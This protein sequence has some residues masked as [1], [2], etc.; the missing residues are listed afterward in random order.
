MQDQLAEIVYY[1][2]AT[3]RY[4]WIILITAWLVCLPA[5]WYVMSL[6]DQY[7]SIARVQ[8]DTRTMLRPL[9][10]GLAIQSDV[11]GMVDVMKQLMFIKQNLEKIAELAGLGKDLKT[12]SEKLGLINRLK[13]SIVIEGGR[14]EIFSISYDAPDPD[15]AKHVVQSVLTVF[16]E[17]AQRSTLDDADSAQRFL[18]TQIQ[19]YE[20]RLRNAEKARENFKRANIGMLPGQGADQVSQIQ[21]LNQ[22]LDESRLNLDELYSR[23][24]VLL[25]QLEEAQESVEDE[26]G[27]FSE[28]KDNEDPRIAELISKRDELLLRYTE[29]HP[30]VKVINDTIKAYRARKLLEEVEMDDSPSEA[31][32]NPFVQ[33]IKA[34][35]NEVDAQ[36]ASLKSRISAYEQRI[37]KSDEEFN[38][39]LNIETQMQNLNRDYGTIK[40]NYQSLLER[41]EQAA[42]SEKVDNQSVA[43]KFKV[44]D[45]PNKPL[46]PSGPNRSLLYTGAMAG[47]L[48][49]GVAIAFLMVLLK[50]SFMAANQVRSITG[51]PILG[52]VSMVRNEQQI[53]KLRTKS[54][55]FTLIFGLL[56]SAYSGMMFL[57]T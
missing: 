5:W 7:S 51:L 34:S 30:S 14:D 54:I 11:R 49:A 52:T 45:P 25:E 36:I 43:L 37:K 23:K 42:M 24:K 12:E 38:E 35:S 50:P 29:K 33:S 19:E 15:E 55:Q 48:I 9:L 32:S 26:W 41:K 10:R 31:L 22:T 53:K 18:M 44:A 2:K 40:A 20:Q 21:H 57:K 47:G 17:Q 39:R 4:K 16:S 1:L 28:G 8:V 3:I 27:P 6:P 13:R 46:S 56:V